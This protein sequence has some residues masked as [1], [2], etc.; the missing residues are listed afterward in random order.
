MVR[1][2]RSKDYYKRRSVE[3]DEENPLIKNN[4]WLKFGLDMMK[5]INK[6]LETAERIY[7]Q[8]SMPNWEVQGKK[9]QPQQGQPKEMSLEEACEI[10][11]VN[12]ET[13]PEEVKKAYRELAKKYHPD[14][15]KGK[16]KEFIK[17]T[18]AYK[19]IQDAMGFT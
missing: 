17:V 10:L 15:V 16:E 3:E 9:E 8:A 7:R 1:R 19:V 13:S 4:P 5:E 14:H 11:G 12:D 18:A 6:S 2:R